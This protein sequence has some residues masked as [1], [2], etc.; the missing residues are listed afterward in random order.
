M[1]STKENFFIFQPSFEKRGLRHK[2]RYIQQWALPK[3][4]KQTPFK[5]DLG[6]PFPDTPSSE[7]AGI[8]KGL[9]GWPLG[10][11]SLSRR[12]KSQPDS[13]FAGICIAPDLEN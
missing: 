13:D 3:W 7:C 12:R 5:G 11:C 4:S 6:F 9:P 10:L 1:F 8:A 2:M